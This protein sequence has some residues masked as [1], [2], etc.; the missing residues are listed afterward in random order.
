VKG[1]IKIDKVDIISIEKYASLKD[2]ITNEIGKVL[3]IGIS[4]N[5]M[6]LIQGANT[7]NPVFIGTNARREYV[8]LLGVSETS[9]VP[10]ENTG[11]KGVKNVGWRESVFKGEI[12]AGSGGGYYDLI[13]RVTVGALEDI[14]YK[15]NYDGAE[16]YK[17]PPKPSP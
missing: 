14:G 6:K 4:E 10:V 8:A 11:K 5:W 13:S 9:G 16:N 12:M 17:L 15:V 1:T 2:F 3:G 7:D